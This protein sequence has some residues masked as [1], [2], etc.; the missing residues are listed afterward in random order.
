MAT[1]KDKIVEQ[2]NQG[3]IMVSTVFLGLDHRHGDGTPLLFETLV[4]GG[5]LADEM[6]RYTSWDQAQAGHNKMVALVFDQ[7]ILA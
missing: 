5:P 3:D 7:A 1:H 2:T 4:F 6:V